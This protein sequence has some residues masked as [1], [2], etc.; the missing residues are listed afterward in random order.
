MEL[1]LQPH[2]LDGIQLGKK[3]LLSK[4]KGSNQEVD[5]NQKFESGD[6]VKMH[7]KE[8]KCTGN[9]TRRR[10]GG[11]ILSIATSTTSYAQVM[12][13]RRERF[14]DCCLYFSYAA[15]RIL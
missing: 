6:N 8:S 12:I 13:A 5:G 4:K 1:Y 11:D 9:R 15:V 2:S 3:F 14:T 7:G 10:S